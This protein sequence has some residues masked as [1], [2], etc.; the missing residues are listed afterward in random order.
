MSGTRPFTSSARGTTDASATDTITIGNDDNA[1]VIN[2]L[3]GTGG[4]NLD[5]LGEYQIDGALVDI[6][7]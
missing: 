3:T 5:L 2:M 1:T 6:G 7:S 4:V